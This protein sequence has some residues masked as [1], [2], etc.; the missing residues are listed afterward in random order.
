MPTQIIPEMS[1]IQKHLNE[2]LLGKIELHEFEDWFV[3]ILWDLRKHRTI[4]RGNWRDT[5][6]TSSRKPLV[7]IVHRIPFVRSW[8]VS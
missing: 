5:S 1:E 4:L 3:S 8:V 7:E 2:Y 6:I